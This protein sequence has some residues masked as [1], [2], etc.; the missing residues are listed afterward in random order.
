MKL[1][2][3]YVIL[4]VIVF[5]KSQ[6]TN[7]CGSCSNTIFAYSDIIAYLGTISG[8]VNEIDRV[9]QAE[10]AVKNA[11]EYLIFNDKKTWIDADLSCFVHGGH[12]V[13]Y[14]TMEEMYHVNSL[15]KTPCTNTVGYWTSGRDLGTNTWIWRDSGKPIHPELWHPQEP[16]Q[17]AKC[18]HLW[19]NVSPYQYADY[20]C[21]S[22]L[23]YI[24]EI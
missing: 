8:K 12:L 23:C 3:I 14:D 21:T 18:G 13:S 6:S 2:Q 15:I 17:N 24:C 4:Q 19:I 5:V 9:L 16:N 22:E 10:R 20:P 7:S 11:S 1:F